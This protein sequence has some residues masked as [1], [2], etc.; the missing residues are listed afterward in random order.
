MNV[1]FSNAV[2]LA[3]DDGAMPGIQSLRMATC[4]GS[5]FDVPRHRR[6]AQDGHEWPGKGLGVRGPTPDETALSWAEVGI[7]LREAMTT[8]ARILEH[9]KC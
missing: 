8:R 5:G 2:G 1:E 4:Q 6:S 3:C 9:D 7:A